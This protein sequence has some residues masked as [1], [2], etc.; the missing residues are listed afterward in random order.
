MYIKIFF[1]DKPL[2]L[3]NEIDETIQPYVHHDDAVFIDELNSHTIKT[4]IHE[5]QLPAVH[6]GIFLHPDIEEL[7]KPFFKKFT[8]VRAAG[9]LVLNEKDEILLIFRRGKWDMPKGKLDEGEKLEDCAIR[10]VE[11]ETGLKKVKLISQLTITYHTY[12]E[13]TKF[14]L[15]E[16][17]WYIMKVNGEQTLIP[18]TEED[19]IEIRWVKGNDLYKYRK[20]SFPSVADVLD[21]FQKNSN[22]FVE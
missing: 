9:G 15:K 17:H 12:H 2:F 8:V 13:G 6:A 16:S 11:E 18:Q 20:D 3:C 19:I 5:M 14:I 21:S 7:K 22:L 1:Q 4:M 10:E